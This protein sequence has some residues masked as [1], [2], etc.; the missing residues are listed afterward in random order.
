MFKTQQTDRESALCTCLLLLF[1]ILQTHR[2]TLTLTLTLTLATERAM[3][4]Y[5]SE[6]S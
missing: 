3:H 2:W 6:L 4:F 1:A 5:Q